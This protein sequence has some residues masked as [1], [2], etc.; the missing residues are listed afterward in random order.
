MVVEEG[1]LELAEGEARAIVPLG[2]RVENKVSEI[3]GE[4]VG[5]VARES[6]AEGESEGL[7]EEVVPPVKV[8]EG[9]GEK[10]EMPVGDIDVV[11]ITLVA[12]EETEGDLDEVEVSE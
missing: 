10:D 12:C 7:G 8:W 11:G 1:G 9:T 4:E 6:D 2:L 3:N 5:E